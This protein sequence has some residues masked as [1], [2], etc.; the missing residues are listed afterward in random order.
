VVV[1]GTAALEAV[2]VKSSRVAVHEETAASL[3]ISGLDLVGDDGACSTGVDLVG[4]ATLTATAFA[5]QKLGTSLQVRDRASA[6]VSDAVIISDRACIAYP[7]S[8]RSSGTF[9]LADS[10][11]VGGYSGPWLGGISMSEPL[12]ASLTNVKVFDTSTRGLGG[13]D[14]IVQVTG[15][16]LSRNFTAGLS[17]HSGSWSLT[18]VAVT[19]NPDVGVTLFGPED[20]PPVTLTMRGCTVTGNLMGVDL[21]DFA[22]VDLGTMDSPG[23]NT[24]QFNTGVGVLLSGEDSDREISAVGNTWMPFVQGAD[25]N[26][27]YIHTVVPGPVGFVNG[28]NY[29]IRTATRRLKL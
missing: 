10:N 13:S 3:I 29:S 4:D 20:G 8:I 14:V 22:N 12:R 24:F 18:N 23:N 26:G 11:F 25:K 1:R 27:K 5:A 19:D 6:A 2:R 28:N 9:L 17:I 21:S 16:E 7:F 15:G